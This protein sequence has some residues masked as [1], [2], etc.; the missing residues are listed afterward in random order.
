[1]AGKL[2]KKMQINGKWWMMMTYLNIRTLVMMTKTSKVAKV[3]R[4]TLV[5]LCLMEGRLSTAMQRIF[6]SRPTNATKLVIRPCKMNS[7]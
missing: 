1:M 2:K 5:E 4:M 6:P 7:K 3:A